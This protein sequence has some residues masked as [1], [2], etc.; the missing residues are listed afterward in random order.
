[1]RAFLIGAILILS[2]SG[3]ATV[4]HIDIDRCW[5]ETVPMC[6]QRGTTSS[7][8]YHSNNCYYVTKRVCF[9]DDGRY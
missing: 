5:Y 1:M 9:T 6:E 4:A 3:C 7:Y 2:L 8:Y